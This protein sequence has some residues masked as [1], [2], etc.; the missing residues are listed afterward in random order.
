MAENHGTAFT[1]YL[2]ALI[3]QLGSD[4]GKAL[5]KYIYDYVEFF[6][7]STLFRRGGQTERAAKKFALIGI[8]G[9]LATAWS[10]TGWPEGAAMFAATDLFKRWVIARG[11]EGNLEEQQMRDH[12]RSIFQKFKESRFKRWDQTTDDKSTIIDSHVP[13]TA[14][15][16]GFRKEIAE[17][18]HLSPDGRTSRL[19]FYVYAEAFKAE[20]CKGFDYRRM[21]NLLLKMGALKLTES[22]KNEKR[23]T[24][25]VRL[26]GTGAKPVN[27]YHIDFAELMAGD[28]G[29]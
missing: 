3:Q 19:E 2:R 9:E 18:E 22:S 13:I 25:K 27:I 24:C 26:P 14:D 5:F 11:G 6:C 20:I 23:F 7:A 16:W 28:P 4:N 21:A 10:V 29:S 15:S 1:A 17:G 12:L 8:A